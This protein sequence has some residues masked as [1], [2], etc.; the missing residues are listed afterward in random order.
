M[1]VADSVNAGRRLRSCWC[2]LQWWTVD[3][4]YSESLDPRVVSRHAACGVPRAVQA[5][6]V[7]QLN[8]DEMSSSEFLELTEHVWANQVKARDLL[9]V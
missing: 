8:R 7:S 6:A 1:L 4:I 2:K 9:A 5:K 3:R